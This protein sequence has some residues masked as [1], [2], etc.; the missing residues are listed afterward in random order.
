MPRRA[1]TGPA[2]PLFAFGFILTAAGTVMYV[3]PDS[4]GLLLLALGSLALAAAVAVWLFA[5]HR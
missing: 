2:S 3:L 4:P 1:R 5:R